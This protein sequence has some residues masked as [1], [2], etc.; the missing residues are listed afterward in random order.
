[1][2]L[3]AAVMRELAANNGEVTKRLLLSETESTGLIRCEGERTW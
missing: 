2:A 3:H 1:M